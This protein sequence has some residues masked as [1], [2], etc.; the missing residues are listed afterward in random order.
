MP[1][2]VKDCSGSMY[3]PYM[4]N[5]TNIPFKGT[6]QMLLTM[7]LTRHQCL[8]K[9][10]SFDWEGCANIDAPLPRSLFGAKKAP[11]VLALS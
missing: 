6:V 1:R 8:C 9:R 2:I 4:V 3:M 7:L 5:A 10:G 11:F